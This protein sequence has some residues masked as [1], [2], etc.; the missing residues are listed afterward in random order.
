LGILSL[1]DTFTYSEFLHYEQLFL[2]LGKNAVHEIS[3]ADDDRKHK[4]YDF[5]L[6]TR[7]TKINFSYPARST[8]RLQRLSLYFPKREE[9]LKCYVD[10]HGKVKVKKDLQ[11]Y[12]YR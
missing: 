10:L 5:Y 7:K 9:V 11:E 4:L 2:V 3:L 6:K 1:R 12:F 8:S